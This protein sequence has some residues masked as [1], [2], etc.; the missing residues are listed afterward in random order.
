MFWLTPLPIVICVTCAA[1]S[2]LRK[3]G[4]THVKSGYTHIKSFVVAAAVAARSGSSSESF[5]GRLRNERGFDGRAR[6]PQS[7]SRRPG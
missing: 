2:N 5:E 4:H 1:P 7:P 3:S 6:W